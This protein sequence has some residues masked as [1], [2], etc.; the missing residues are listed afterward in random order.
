MILIFLYIKYILAQLWRMSKDMKLENKY[1]PWK[2]SDY[3]WNIPD[4]GQE[5]HIEIQDNNE[6][7]SINDKASEGNKLRIHP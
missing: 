1:G 5:G 7:L 2:Y 4:E 3:H 6:V